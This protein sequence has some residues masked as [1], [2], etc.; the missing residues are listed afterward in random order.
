MNLK[1]LAAIFLL[2]IAVIALLGCVEEPGSGGGTGPGGDGL[3]QQ[4]DQVVGPDYHDSEAAAFD[5][6]GQELDDIPEMSAE[7]LEAMLGA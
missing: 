6:L 5:A 4:P 2:S 7:D 1:Q 3:A